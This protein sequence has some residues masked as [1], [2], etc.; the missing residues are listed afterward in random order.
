M[1][2]K[3]IFI[4]LSVGLISL[5]SK[6][7]LGDSIKTYL[8]RDFERAKAYTQEYLNVMPAD[9]YSFKP[10]DSVRTFAEQMLH[11]ADGNFGIAGVASGRPVP[12]RGLEKMANPVKDSVVMAVNASYDF[13]INA[14]KNTNSSEL[15]QVAKMGTMG[16]PKLV[17]YNKVFEHQTHHRGQTTVYIRTLGLKPPPERLF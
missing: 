16:F 13:V 17:W 11:I 8:I 2:C 3:K 1:N 14:L 10:N 12:R 9:K 5:T 15:M 4:L 7:Q 6:A